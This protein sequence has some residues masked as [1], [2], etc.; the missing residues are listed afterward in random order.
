MQIQALVK[1]GVPRD[2]IVLEKGSAA[3][4]RPALDDLLSGIREGDELV[5]WKMDRIARSLKDLLGKMEYIRQAGCG[6]RSLTEQIDISTP[7]GR[8]LFHVL[9]ALAEFE[10]DLIVERTKSGVKRAKER[11]VRFGQERKLTDAQIKQA[12]K[13]RDMGKTTREIADHFGVSHNTIRN[14]TIQRNE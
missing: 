13:M 1:A 9:G 3:K 8:L 11:G 5:V 6:F 7:G 12:Q 4:R 10:R 14:W 2:N